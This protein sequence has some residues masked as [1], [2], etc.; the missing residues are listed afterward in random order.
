[1]GT[2]GGDDTQGKAADLR[3]KR[4]QLMLRRKQQL[5]SKEA[6]R[7]EAVGDFYAA[8][9]CYKT[10]YFQASQVQQ[11]KRAIDSLH[12]GA[13]RMFS[14]QQPHLGSELSLLLIEALRDSASP[15]LPATLSLLREICAQCEQSEAASSC[16]SSTAVT[17][18]PTA[19]SSTSSSSSGAAAPTACKDSLLDRL[20]RAS[21]EWSANAPGAP[22]GFRAV[23]PTPP[24][25]TVPAT[26]AAAAD[27]VAVP[28]AGDPALHVY[29]ADVLVKRGELGMA[30]YHLLR[31]DAP[32]RTLHYLL[33]MTS[34][35]AA[36]EHDLFLARMV[37]GYVARGNLKDAHLVLTG[38]V[39]ERFPGSADSM[40]D[41]GLLPPP[42]L[43]NF[44]RFLL[45]TLERDNTY[46]L[47]Q[48]LCQVYAPSLARDPDFQKNLDKVAEVFYNVK[49]QPQG[50]AG[51]M[52]M[53]SSMFQAPP[54]PRRT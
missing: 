15:H 49:K 32:T 14:A 12:T 33:E 5:L 34:K 2:S 38:F 35:A 22:L 27:A 19:P 53:V 20:V 25:A 47:Y 39:A 21:L 30:S 24:A 52:N 28:Y 6:T 45:L 51:I 54:Q 4:R 7:H 13:S 44:L 42:P 16:S 37:L 50:L 1:M 9:Q 11:W 31:G 41:D 36:Q 23:H 46:P 48:R 26:N 18:S 10:L 40:V 8:Q 29:Y 3:Q 17:A 43:V